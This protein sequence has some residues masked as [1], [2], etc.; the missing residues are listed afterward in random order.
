MKL[1]PFLRAWSLLSACAAA[2]LLAA[3]SAPVLTP[4]RSPQVWERAEFRIEAAPVAANN[5]DPDQIRIDATITAPSGRAM[6]VPAYWAQDY[7]HALAE[8]QEALT[9]SGTA[10]WRLRYTPTEPG[11]HE[12]ELAITQPGVPATRTRQDFTVAARTVTG[13]HG[14]VQIASDHRY[15][16]TSDGQPLRLVGENV[17]WP[18]WRGTFDYEVWFESMRRSGQNFA[19]L[20]MCP[21]SLSL[22]Q[23]A[24]SLTRYSQDAAWRLDRIFELAEQKGIYLLLCLDFHGMY[25]L[26]N[27]HWGG[28]GNLWP[29]NP[30]QQANGGPCKEPNDFFSNPA[31]RVLYEKRL[32]YLV[33]RYGA[34]TH[35]LAWQFFNEIDNAYQWGRLNGADVAAW[36]RDVGHWLKQADPFR[37]LVT[38]SL[39]GGSDRPEIWSLPEMDVAVYHS[40]GDAAP[41][42]KFTTLVDDYARRYAKPVLIGEFGVDVWG[43]GRTADPHL[44]GFRQALW[45]GALSGSV[46]SATSWWWDEIHT[47][48]AYPIYS[49]LTQVLD[50]AGWREGV[51]TPAVAEPV[52]SVPP[53]TA[54]D[55]VPNGDFYTG[56]V[57][58][59]GVA[60]FSQ[61]KEVALTGALAAERGADSLSCYL[62]PTNERYQQRQIVLDGWWAN[63]GKITF[64]VTEADGDAEPVVHIDTKE[65]WR[66]KLARPAGT[67]PGARKLDQEFSVPIP[68]GHHRVELAN[69]APIWMRIDSLRVTSLRA[70]T[71]PGGW[72][73][74]PTVTALRQAEKALVYVV[75]PW[76]AYP[77]GAL[78]YH[79]P[80]QRGRSVNLRAWPDGKFIAH[81]F[82]PETGAEV[83]STAVTATGGTLALPLPD[84][85]DDLAGLIERAP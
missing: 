73:Y 52:T 40:Y 83:T 46:G 3:S 85:D 21:W 57:A 34:S 82:N 12:V 60:W 18:Q 80:L 72:E 14:W 25:Q 53:T 48:N 27:P 31:A 49:A 9:P 28:S 67:A 2:S 32:R 42:Q 74:Q 70:S 76:S 20:W 77:A 47:D 7:T 8:G 84:F 29:K 54:G 51:W 61:V 35:L 33:G 22:E 39:T 64:H 23:S 13:R 43:W 1:L 4:L 17:C 65:V 11:R 55:L 5:Y 56:N 75:S 16:E 26:D 69:A 24:D 68:G 63:D 50:R 59:N 15:L 19:R 45:G 58:L 36:H 81:W 10:G 79:P 66:T 78:R 41:A 37:H 30:Y 71:Y 44:R 6:T 38:T 62:G